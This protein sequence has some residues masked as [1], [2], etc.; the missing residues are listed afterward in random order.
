MAPPIT[1]VSGIRG[2]V[3]ESLSPAYAAQMGLKFGSFVGESG[4]VAIACDTRTTSL[5]IKS[6][7]ISGLLSSGCTVYDLGTSSTPSVFKEVQTRHFEGG[8]IVTASHN[9]PEWNG[10]KFVTS[11]GRGVFESEFEKI[12]NFETKGVYKNGRLIRRPALYTEILKIKAGK[13]SASGVKVSLDLAGGVGSLFIPSLLNYQGCLVHTLHDSP[14]IF[15]R[16]IDPTV[17]P[18]SALS[19]SLI[20]ESCNIGF[21][22]DCDADRL[23]IVDDKGNKLSGDATLIICLQHLQ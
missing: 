1:S 16:I 19:D 8:I 21:A 10:L 4:K 3:G 17:D 13:D 12:L 11:G 2:S 9:P 7:V 5:T 22:F 20:S 15:P 23:V 18:L 6:S 14:G